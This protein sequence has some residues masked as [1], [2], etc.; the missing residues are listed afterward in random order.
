MIIIKIISGYITEGAKTTPSYIILNF[1]DEDNE[2][3]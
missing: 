3:K 1:T 2:Y